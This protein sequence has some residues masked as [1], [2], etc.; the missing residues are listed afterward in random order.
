MFSCYII[1]FDQNNFDKNTFGSAWQRLFT[2]CFV[3]ESTYRE[4]CIGVLTIQVFCQTFK[5]ISLVYI[6]IYL[7]T[8]ILETLK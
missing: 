5:V 7:F 4:K 8:K 3:P 6:I 1:G 2:I